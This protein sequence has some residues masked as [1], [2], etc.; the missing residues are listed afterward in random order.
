MRKVLLAVFM[1]SVTLLTGCATNTPPEVLLLQEEREAMSQNYIEVSRALIFNL[2]DQLE[3]ACLSEAKSIFDLNMKMLPETVNK[4]EMLAAFAEYQ[5]QQA[6]ILKA[7][8]AIRLQARKLDISAA[9]IAKLGSELDYYLKINRDATAGLRMALETI[10]S[11]W[12]V[13]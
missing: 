10:K 6:S 2:C 7:V 3:G 11:S 4:V 5:Q 12:E 9:Q 1:L 13:K 8:A